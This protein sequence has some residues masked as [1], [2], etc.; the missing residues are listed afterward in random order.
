MAIE[1]KLEVRTLTSSVNLEK[2]TSPTEFRKR[3]Y[4]SRKRY[5]AVGKTRYT[6]TTRQYV[7]RKP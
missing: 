4:V 2:I 6:T 5:S 7:S 3:K 1:L